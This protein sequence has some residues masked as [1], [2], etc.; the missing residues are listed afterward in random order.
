MK[1]SSSEERIG[2]ESHQESS[3]SPFEVDKNHDFPNVA[4]ERDPIT[5]STPAAITESSLIDDFQHINDNELGG[6]CESESSPFFSVQHLSSLTVPD[7]E[8]SLDVPEEVS[9]PSSPL[10][11]AALRKRTAS[12]VVVQLEQTSRKQFSKR[13]RRNIASGDPGKKL[14]L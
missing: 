12:V 4:T 14:W 9:V 10:E 13:P 6:S 3:E 2:P 1:E 5:P 8:Q 7:I 11:Q